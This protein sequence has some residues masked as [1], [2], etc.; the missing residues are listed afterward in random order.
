MIKYETFDAALEAAKELNGGDCI[1]TMYE[2]VRN[3]DREM[4]ADH[5]PFF[6]T[7]A[8]NKD[9]PEIY[10]CYNHGNE[11]LMNK[12]TVS[13]SCVSRGTLTVLC[14]SHLGDGEYMEAAINLGAPNGDRKRRKALSDFVAQMN[15][16]AAD[17]DMFFMTMEHELQKSGDIYDALGNEHWKQQLL[18]LWTP[19]LKT[20]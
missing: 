2:H 19:A 6:V 14:M 5:G 16:R 8:K 1:Y 20:A 3:E 15:D 13:S 18:D 4:L 10:F 17:G 12:I 7:M 11:R 9:Y